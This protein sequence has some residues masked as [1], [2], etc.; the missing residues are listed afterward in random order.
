VAVL[1]HR[2]EGVG[3][4]KTARLVGVSKDTVVRRARKAGG[5]AQQLHDERVGFSP[6][7]PGGAVR[8]EVVLRG[9]EEEARPAAD[10]AEDLGR[11]CW[12]HGA[13]DA[14]SR[15]VLRVVPG[16]PSGEHTPLLVEDVQRR[17]G[18]RPRRQG[19]RRR[20]YRQRTPA[21]AAKRTD[22]V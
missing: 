13:L 5:P 17:T 12:D 19:S 6:L 20:G 10:P 18:G 21:M 14:E 1:A 22:H 16:R 7:H 9:H 11:D 3:V 8:R 15:L 4:R 2:A